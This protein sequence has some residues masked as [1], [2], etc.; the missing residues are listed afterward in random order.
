MAIQRDTFPLPDVDEPLTAPFFAGAARDE[1]V[2][3]RCSPC[4]RYVWYPEPQCPACGGPL[5][6]VE[7]RGTGTLFSWAVV[8]R[9]FLPA[10]AEQV[11]FVS[12]LVALD[13]DPAVRIVSYVVAAAPE[14]LVPGMPL[15]VAFRDLSFPTVPRASVRV[16]VFRPSGGG[17][18]GR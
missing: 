15:T 13:D 8:R 2:L 17:R 1:L 6:W 3:P 9:P 4:D 10:F 5:D 16:P 18:A 14:D 12:A 7:V 11:P